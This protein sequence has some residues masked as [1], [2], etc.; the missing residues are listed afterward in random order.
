M[1][2]PPAMHTVT[3]MGMSGPFERS[4]HKLWVHP[5]GPSHIR[6]LDM[7]QYERA[8]PESGVPPE[9]A[10]VIAQEMREAGADSIWWAQAWG[11]VKG[12]LSVFWDVRVATMSEDAIE[13][14]RRITEPAGS[15]QQQLLE[16]PATGGLFVLA[17]SPEVVSV[18]LRRQP[19]TRRPAGRN[20]LGIPLWMRTGELTVAH[21]SVADG[22]VGATASVGAPTMREVE[23]ASS[24]L[25]HALLADVT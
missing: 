23:L 19:G 13:A 8:L 11:G 4:D 9:Q 21:V 10:S 20:R 17:K 3:S 22:R 7:D 25:G 16:A 18:A 2:Q 14:V 6:V 5:P 12:H 1:P 24:R 15:D